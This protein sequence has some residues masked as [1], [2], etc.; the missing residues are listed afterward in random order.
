M[1]IKEEP[2]KTDRKVYRVHC[3]CDH[4]E[5]DVV[6]TT[7]SFRLSELLGTPDHPVSCPVCTSDLIVDDKEEEYI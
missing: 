6:I 2:I 7:S 4:C 1:E 5:V 3:S